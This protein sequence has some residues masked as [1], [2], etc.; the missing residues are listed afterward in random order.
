MIVSNATAQGDR[1]YQE[2]Y[3][4]YYTPP[5]GMEERG[6]LLLLADGMGGMAGGATASL[7]AVEHFKNAYYG[8]VQ[9]LSASADIP[10]ILARIITGANAHLL[11]AS[12][13]EIKLTGM[14]TTLI[15][16]VVSGGRLYWASIG[17]SHLYLLRDGRLQLLNEDHSIGGEITR[18][19][20]TGEMTPEFAKT[21]DGQHHKLLHYLGNKNF[22][23]FDLS[24][25]PV[26]LRTDDRVLM[27]SDGLHGT[28]GEDEM[29]QVLLKSDPE[30]SANELVQAA[31][32]QGVQ[33]QDNIT[34]QV[35]SSGGNWASSSDGA[36][37]AGRARRRWLALGLCAMVLVGIAAAGAFYLART[38]PAKEGGVRV[39][40]QEN[41]GNGTG[42]MPLPQDAPAPQRGKGEQSSAQDGAQAVAGGAAPEGA[43]V[44][45]VKTANAKQGK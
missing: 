22:G 1:P 18:K 37:G 17:D 8:A 29:A 26:E 34:V 3:H 15:A 7:M 20:A 32:R 9:G 35:A 30:I 25:A 27:C 33:G 10:S 11:D 2:D 43:A 19:L 14:G 39:M 4:A 44:A 12:R 23:H 21:L 41:A 13:S 24:D 31:L 5:A 16:A 45:P 40:L 28:L 38:Q 42:G 36:G 6:T